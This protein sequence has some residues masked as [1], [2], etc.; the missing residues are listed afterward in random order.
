MPLEVFVH[1]AL[2]VAYS[3]QCLTSES[4]GGRSANRGQCAQACRLPYE[5]VCDGQ[6][7]DLGEQQYLLSPQDLAAF[8]AGARADRRRRLLVQDRRP[9]E[10]A[11]VRGQHHAALPPGDRQRRWR[12]GRSSS[13][14]ATS[15][16][17]SCRSRA[18]SRPAGSAAA[19]TRCSCRRPVRPSA[20]CCWATCEQVRGE[21]RDGRAAARRSSAA[22]ASSSPAI[23]PKD[24][25]SK[26]AACTKCSQSAARSPSRSTA[27]V[28]Q[29]TF[30]HG[31]IDFERLPA[32][33]ADLEDRRSG[34]DDAGCARS[35]TGAKPQRRV[36]LDLRS[37]RRGRPA[38]G[39]STARTDAGVE[40]P[41]R[42]ARAAGRSPQASA[43]ARSARASSSAGLAARPTNCASCHGRD[44]RQA[45]GAAERAG[46]AAARAGAA[47]GRGGRPI[48]P[49]AASPSIRRCAAAPCAARR[50]DRA[51]TTAEHAAIA[52]ALPFAR[53]SSTRRAGLRRVERDG[54]LPGHPRVSR[55]GADWPMRPARRF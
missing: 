17:W 32:G 30:G 16:R 26:A 2:C 22:T 10:D 38:A 50:D 25:P 27:G 47:A 53:R 52:R 11:R 48:R 28:V 55:R 18:A 4:L 35:F 23:A 8:D 15:R 19:I 51:T 1:G 46:Q 7:V 5:L 9:A 37:C 44:R 34:A 36:P 21:S 45:D 33:P 13:R 39:R 14:R 41:C 24:E 20:A 42:I 3:G 31:A 49:S 12:A 40:L 54:R 43:H 6:D 29:L